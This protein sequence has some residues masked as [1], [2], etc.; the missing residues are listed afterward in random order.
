MR[1]LNK[2]HWVII[3]AV[4]LAAAA[5]VA[6]WIGLHK[7]INQATKREMV[8]TVVAD[9]PPMTMLT[10]GNVKLID[11]PLSSVNEY[12]VKAPADIIGQ[13]TTVPL[14][15]G[16]MIDK[17]VIA[18]PSILGNCQLVGIYT[19]PARYAGVQ[20]NDVVDIYWVQQDKQ[21][22]AAVIIAKDAKVY[23]IADE[24]GSTIKSNNVVTQAVNSA[25]KA[26][27]IVYLLVKPEEAPYVINGA[28][29]NKTMALVK[30]SLQGGAN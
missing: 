13:I 24:A 21:P 18:Q 8:V 1:R 27:K 19:D 3:I 6:S 5:A 7:Q 17:R 20:E 28:I 15:S 23:K 26:P 12:I 4:V 29:D 25:T 30:K 9:M 10:A 22:L 14:F 11:V 2:K 16:G